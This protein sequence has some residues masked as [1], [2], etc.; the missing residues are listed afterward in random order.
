MSAPSPLI[1]K[2]E[3]RLF[4]FAH[5]EVASI[6]HPSVLAHEQVGQLKSRNG[7]VADESP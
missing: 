1:F 5:K 7:V 2:P 4:F 3:T 6:Y